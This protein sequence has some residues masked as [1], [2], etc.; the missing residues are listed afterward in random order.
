M[1]FLPVNDPPPV[2]TEKPANSKSPEH[3]LV[4]RL[5]SVEELHEPSVSPIMNNAVH[6]LDHTPTTMATT[7]E[8]NSEVASTSGPITFTV[9]SSE[10]TNEN[11]TTTSSEVTNS[12]DN[13]IT[14]RLSSEVDNSVTMTTS[15]PELENPVTMTTSSQVDITTTTDQPQETKNINTSNTNNEVTTEALPSNDDNVTVI[16]HSEVQ[17][18]V[19][20]NDSV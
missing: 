5:S 13:P 10:E 18:Q 2:Y 8:T 12:N 3:L 6:E 7:E 16:D 11:V 19:T 14:V 9:T 17:I 1:C 20:I 4:P 15:S